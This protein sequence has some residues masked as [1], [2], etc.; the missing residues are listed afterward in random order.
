[1]F[2]KRQSSDT[3][4]LGVP[5]LVFT[6]CSHAVPN[7][8][9]SRGALHD[10]AGPGG[11]HLASPT[12]GAAY[13]M[14]RKERVSLSTVPTTTPLSVVTSALEDDA[15]PLPARGTAAA[16]APEDTRPASPSDPMTMAR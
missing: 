12:G 5:K 3:P 1:M 11:A 10:A 16:K 8:V 15:P 2:R 6:F 9:A 14:P 7:F 4:T 13:G